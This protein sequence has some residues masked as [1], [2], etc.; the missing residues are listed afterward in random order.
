[1]QFA[2]NMQVARGVVLHHDNAYPIQPKQPRREFK[3][4]SGNF[5]ASDFCLFGL[6]RNHLCGNCFT[7]D[8]EVET[9]MQKWLRQKSKGFN[10]AGFD[11][12]VKQWNKCIDVDGG[13]IEKKCLFLL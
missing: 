4:Y 2:D 9:E 12:L 3:D 1:M 11:A 6:L 7:D 13:Y 10:A 8:E 5:L